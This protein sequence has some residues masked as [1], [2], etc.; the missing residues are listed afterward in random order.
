MSVILTSR[1]KTA[2][3]PPIPR[4]TLTLRSGVLQENSLQNRYKAPVSPDEMGDCSTNI[5]ELQT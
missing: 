3:Q 5:I 2:G 4:V 1:N